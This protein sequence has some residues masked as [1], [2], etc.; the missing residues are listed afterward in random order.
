[1]RGCWR[2]SRRWPR[3]LVR[4]AIAACWRWCGTPRIPRRCWPR[5]PGKVR[6]R[7]RRAGTGGFGY[8]PLFVPRGFDQTVAQLPLAVKNRLSHRAVALALLVR[9]LSRVGS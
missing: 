3:A 4:R 6:S 7:S 2:N 5:A 1:M 8:D 9:E